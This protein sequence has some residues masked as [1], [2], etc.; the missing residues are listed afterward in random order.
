MNILVVGDDFTPF[1]LFEEHLRAR[2]SLGDANITGFDIASDCY[3][4]P[5]LEVSEYFGDPKVVMV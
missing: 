2:P 5:G 1:H 4:P 3:T